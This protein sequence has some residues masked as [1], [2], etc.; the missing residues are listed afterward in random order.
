[1]DK[2]DPLIKPPPPSLLPEGLAPNK[3]LSSDYTTTKTNLETILKKDCIDKAFQEQTI[4]SATKWQKD[5]FDYSVKWA[6]NAY[7]KQE[8]K[9]WADVLGDL[10]YQISR[11]KLC[12]PA[13]PDKAK[14]TEAPKTP[15]APKTT[16]A[17]KTREKQIEEIKAEIKSLE[18]DIEGYDFKID[19]GPGEHGA[20]AFT[21]EAQK[22]YLDGLYKKTPQGDK[23]TNPN[24]YDK[25][26]LD[27]IEDAEDKLKWHKKQLDK[28]DA[29]IK[30][31]KEKKEKA[32]KDIEQKQKKLSELEKLKPQGGA[33]KSAA[34]DQGK[35]GTGLKTPAKNSAGQGSGGDIQEP[36]YASKIDCP[37]PQEI[38]EQ[39]EIRERMPVEINSVITATDSEAWCTYG[40]GIGLDTTITQ[41]DE[42]GTPIT[43][44]LAEETTTTPGGKPTEPVGTPIVPETPPAEATPS[45]PTSETPPVTQEEPEQPPETPKVAEPLPPETPELT[46]KVPEEPPPTL[47][48][49]TIFVKAKELVLEGQTTGNPIENQIVKLF[50]PEEPELPGAGVNKEAEDAG[51]DKDPVEC[52]TGADGGCKMHVPVEDRALYDL[53]NT[54]EKPGQNYRVDY[55]LPKDSG[56]V[57][58]TT[59]KST[60]PD[61]KTGMPDGAEVAVVEF[62]IGDRTFVR[63]VYE[64]PHGLNHD[65]DEQFKPIFGDN[66]EEDY[67]RE[68][69]PGPPL[70]MQPASLGSVNHDLPEAAIKLGATDP[71]LRA[72]P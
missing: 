58:E 46:E 54:D 28:V 26:E 60:E 16:E 67:C 51:F 59:A 25:A 68:K 12:E 18:G 2:P 17:P 40:D 8:A 5:M 71:A 24:V 27:A 57:A 61:V 34:T 22:T 30:Q 10:I 50:P 53:P 11:M 62:K 1:M 70:G 47:I 7:Q 15:E 29:D 36:L 44:A 55:D 19:L 23:I 6:V 52:T 41:T 33:S 35:E 45:E 20:K 64:Q 66:Y 32:K 37:P 43:V 14:T 69:Q 4:A 42:N 56:A 9:D 38:I 39:T 3:E 49:D 21:V 48:P 65:F 13:C 63:L 72:T 31:A